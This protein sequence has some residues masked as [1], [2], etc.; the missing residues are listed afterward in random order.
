MLLSVFDI[1]DNFSEGIVIF[2]GIL[3]ITM[4]YNVIGGITS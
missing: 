1:R 3:N 4:D 2:Q